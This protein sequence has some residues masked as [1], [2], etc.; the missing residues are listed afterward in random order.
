MRG[1][2]LQG[3]ETIHLAHGDFAI[4]IHIK[5]LGPQT[6][7]IRNPITGKHDSRHTHAS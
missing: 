1:L 4:A 7:I 3:H 2:E 6:A 5:P